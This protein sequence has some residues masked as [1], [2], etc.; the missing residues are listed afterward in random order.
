MLWT[1]DEVLVG[2][3]EDL[4]KEFDLEGKDIPRKEDILPLLDVD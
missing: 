1:L 2:Y 3:N 4:A